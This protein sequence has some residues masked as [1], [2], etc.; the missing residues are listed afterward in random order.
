MPDQT[1]ANVWNLQGRISVLTNEI[2]ENDSREEKN[3]R[4]KH[5]YKVQ[6]PVTHKDAKDQ[7]DKR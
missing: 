3:F 1:K 7:P 6:S 4:V 2:E 5:G